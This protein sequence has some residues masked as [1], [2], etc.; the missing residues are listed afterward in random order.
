LLFIFIFIAAAGL[1]IINYG[2]KDYYKSRIQDNINNLKITGDYKSKVII[3]GLKSPSSFTFDK[4]GNLFIAENTDGKG[5]IIEYTKDGNYKEIIN[6]LSSPISQIIFHRDELYIS[7]KGTISKLQNNM[8]KDIITGLPSLGDYSNNGICFGYD[9]MIYIC[10]GAATNSGIVGIDNFHRG[11]LTENPYFHDYPPY[12]SVLGGMNFKSLNPL[13]SNKNS[14]ANT[15]AFQPFNS[16]SLKS[17]EIKGRLPGNA[18]ILR[19]SYDGRIV[20]AFA[21]GVRNP[22][23]VIILPD[24]R[25]FITAQ[26]MEDRGSRPVANG[27]D[28]LYEIKK[29]EWLGWPDYEGGEPV[30]LNKFKSKQSTRPLQFITDLHPIIKPTKPL[31]AFN[32]SGRI[33]L[34]DLCNSASF[35]YKGQLVIPFK[36]GKKEEA[37]IIIFDLKNNKYI[38]FVSNAKGSSFLENPVQCS[39]SK[40]GKLY[41][42]ENQRGVLMEIEKTQ[43]EN[44]SELPQSIPIE[45]FIGTLVIVFIIYLIVSIKG[46]GK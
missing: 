31:A 46:H 42:L 1:I 20:D 10:Q 8:L 13:I 32:E 6:N 12:D 19:V 38:D 40:D 18:C 24:T 4:A 3:K 33:G 41:V 36:K 34:M 39:F 28:Y 7:Q 23:G 26:G 30:T 16:I 14:G 25:V 37:K 22:M 35:G 17:E 2:F 45:Y 44:N 43:K 27:G 5:S 29:G 9:G 11:W 21:W 15:G